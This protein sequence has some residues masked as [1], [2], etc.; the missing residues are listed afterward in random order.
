MRAAVL[1][2]VVLG[3]QARVTEVLVYPG[4]AELH[5]EVAV[6]AGAQEAVFACIP[7]RIELDSLRARGEGGVRVGE[8]SV[9]TRGP[10][11]GC[12]AQPSLDEPIRQLEDRKAGFK[13]E[14]DALELQLQVLRRGGEQLPSATVLEGVRRQAAE[15]L[16]QQHQLARQMEQ[17][18]EQLKPLL[19]QRGRSGVTQWHEVRV[20]VDAAQAGRVQLITRSP[21]AG[22]RPVYRAE[23]EGQQLRLERRAEV[24]QTTGDDWEGVSLTLSTRQPE[25]QAAPVEPQPW[26]LSKLEPR[27]AMLLEK[28]QVSG[29]R[30]QPMAAAAPAPVDAALPRF[31]TDMDVQFRVPGATRLNSGAERRSFS[32]ERLSWPAETL[33]QVQPAVQAQAYRVALVKRPD[34]FF[35]PG[36]M[37]LYRDGERVGES[38]FELGNEAEQRFGFG[39]EDRLRVRAEPE[40]RDGGNAGFIGKRRELQL[41]R[42][43][44]VENTG[45]QALTVEVLEASPVSEHEE[46]K[47]ESRFEPAVQAGGVRDIPGLRR[48]LLTLAPGQRQLLSASYRFSAPQDMQVQG[49]P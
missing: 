10:E 26:L 5:R 48:W 35:P 32:L 20:R 29:S 2:M 34:G 30:I 28:V 39:P 12:R 11:S 37:Q 31:E 47:V 49:W 4:G 44:T 8:I 14:R 16:R 41:T 33:V 1:M 19:A 45:K 9:Q 36:P 6:A 13:A 46:I 18:D 24:Q 22:W 7:A 43:Y 23:L 21:Q 17:I 25:R 27:S 40:Q 38:P 3:A 42:R 15:A